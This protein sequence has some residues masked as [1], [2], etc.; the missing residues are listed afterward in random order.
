MRVQSFATSDV[1]PG[2]FANFVIWVWSEQAPSLNSVTVTAKVLN[3]TNLGSPAFIVCP[4]SSGATCT[5]GG[6]NENQADELEAMVE[7]PAQATVGLQWQLS[8][9]ASAAG[10]KSFSGT[11]TDVVTATAPAPTTTPIASATTP[12]PSGTVAP[13]AGTSVSPTNPS[14]LFPTVGASPTGTGSVNLPPAK[15]R[16]ALS[17]ATTAADVPLDARLLGGQI[18]GLAVLAGAIAIAIA[19]LSLRRQKVNDPNAPK[20]PQQ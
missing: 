2:S 19:R 7:V 20:P 8:A 14:S 4:A 11:A 15:A 12:A 18:A 10:A 17:G 5:L 3:A 6:L 1:A 13:V 9:S 16:S